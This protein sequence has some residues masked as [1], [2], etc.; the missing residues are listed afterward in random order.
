MN[1][2]SK[3]HSRPYF[4]IRMKLFDLFKKVLLLVL[5]L[6]IVKFLFFDT[7]SIKTDILSTFIKKGDRILITRF[8]SSAP[9]KYFVKPSFGER[10]LVKYPSH[11]ELGILRIAGKPGDSISI[12]DCEIIN[13]SS[14]ESL[15]NIFTPLI[16]EEPLASEYSPRDNMKQYIIPKKGDTLVPPSMS[17]RDII[18][19]FSIISREENSKDIILKKDLY[20]DDSLRND[21]L[22]KEFYRYTGKFSDIP[23]SLSS[24][25]LFWEQLTVYLNKT[26][27]KERPNIR[28]TIESKSG[29]G[30]TRYTVKN[31][32]YFMISDNWDSGLDSRY[33]GP[34]SHAEIKGRVFM[35]LWSINSDERN[36]FKK[37]Q[38]R[39]LLK[40]IGK[41]DVEWQK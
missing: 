22:I 2:D 1:L 35:I 25:Y 14:E 38:F 10:V 7:F 34:I 17:I 15:K 30:Y 12:K 3:I 27:E 29:E 32:Y 28:Y 9:F 21:F 16:K 39:R 5:F 8:I 41:Q 36:I 37:L 31:D 11:N 13:S 6:L 20:I 40:F 26:V 33:F 4:D 24:D 19:S 18:Y 23:D